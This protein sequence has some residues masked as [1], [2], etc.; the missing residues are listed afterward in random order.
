MFLFKPV[1]HFAAPCDCSGS[2]EDVWHFGK[3]GWV[4]AWG[5]FRKL[6]SHLCLANTDNYI[7]LHESCFKLSYHF[8]CNVMWWSQIHTLHI[9]LHHR[10]CTSMAKS[11]KECRYFTLLSYCKYPFHSFWHASVENLT[12]FNGIMKT[13]NKIISV[14]SVECHICQQ[15]AKGLGCCSE[16]RMAM[17]KGE[18]ISSK[19]V[20]KNI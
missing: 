8:C 10:C 17:K 2:Y 7:W 1:E 9:E 6:P 3:S 14:L 11:A 18:A 16:N 20:E 12:H 19:Y 4:V 5:Q 13:E 15:Q